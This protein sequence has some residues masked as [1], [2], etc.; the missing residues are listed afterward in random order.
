MTYRTAGGWL[1]ASLL[2]R[3]LITPAHAQQ[4]GDSV[5]GWVIPLLVRAIIY[6]ADTLPKISDAQ[7]PIADLEHPCAFSLINS[8]SVAWHVAGVAPLTLSI[9][10]SAQGCSKL[11]IG[12]CSP[13]TC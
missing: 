5:A 11:A 7:P 4:R 12:G 8:A 10:L 3:A 9:R 2:I 13:E 1:A 6:L